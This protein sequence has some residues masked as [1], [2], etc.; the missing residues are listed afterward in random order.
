M[1]S[2]KKYVFTINERINA[3]VSTMQTIAVK[4]LEE[5]GNSSTLDADFRRIAF[6]ACELVEHLEEEM[7]KRQEYLRSEDSKDA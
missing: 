1:V 5:G 3:A 7:N 4:Y 6:I 2:Q